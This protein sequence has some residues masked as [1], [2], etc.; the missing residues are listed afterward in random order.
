MCPE[1]KSKTNKLVKKYSVGNKDT[2][3][4][5]EFEFK[6]PICEKCCKSNA[7]NIL[8]S[9]NEHGQNNVLIDYLQRDV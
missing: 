2:G 8:L 4:F 3:H 6:A 5:H 1:C 9:L 7:L